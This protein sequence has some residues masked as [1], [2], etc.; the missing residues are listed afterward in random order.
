[1]FLIDPQCFHADPFRIMHAG[2]QRGSGF[3]ASIIGVV[4]MVMV[5]I[6]VVQV[7]VVVFAVY[8]IVAGIM[9]RVSEPESQHR[10]PELWL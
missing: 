9:Y 1:M 10:E 4:D 7:V 6:G 2:S 5:I 3:C 8:G